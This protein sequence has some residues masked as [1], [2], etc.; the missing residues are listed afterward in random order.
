MGNFER[1]WGL[2]TFDGQAKYEVE[3]FRGVKGLVNAQSVDYLAPR[4]C[5]VNNNLDMMNASARAT[6]ACM[7]A[8]CTALSPGSSCFNL[9]WPGMRLIVTTRNMIK[10]LRVVILGGL[11]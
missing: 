2:F 3:F 9:S 1:H 8:D 6:E 10:G 11:G 4:W 5:V 7:N